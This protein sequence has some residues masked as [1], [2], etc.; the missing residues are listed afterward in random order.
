MSEKY[1]YDLQSKEI[2]PPIGGKFG[3]ACQPVIVLVGGG[4]KDKVSLSEC[5]GS[6]PEEASDKAMQAAEQW[7][8][9]KTQPV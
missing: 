5:W 7:I 1:E 4:P 8:S 9:E 2:N 6:T 3:F